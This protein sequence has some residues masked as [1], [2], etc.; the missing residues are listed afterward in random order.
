M[1]IKLLL[2]FAC[3]ILFLST[4][5][6]QPLMWSGEIVVANGSTYGKMRPRVAVASGNIP[7]VMWGG[8][9]SGEPLYAARWNGSGFDTPVM[10][11]PVNVDPF[12]DVW[13]GAEI[14]ANGNDVFVVYK[15]EPHMTNN[16]YVVKS[17]DGGIT[18][19]LPVQADPGSGPLTDLPS[20]AVTG[21]GNPSVLF[22]TFDSVMANP[23]YAIS[24][25][26]DGGLTYPVAT[27]I[28]DSASN[29]VCDCCPAYLAIKG[30]YFVP[31]WRRNN[32]NMRDMWIAVSNDG[33][34]TF[35]DAIDID[36]TDW[37]LTSCPSSGPSPFLTS[38]SVVTAFMSGASGRNRIYISTASYTT[39]QTGFTQF[40]DSSVTLNA[41][42]NYP[43]LAG[44]GDTLALVYQE[45]VSGNTDAIYAYSYTGAAGLIENTYVLNNS[46]AGNQ[47]NPHVAYASNT[48]HFVWVDYVTGNVMYKTGTPTGIFENENST[49][50]PVYPNPSNEATRIEPGLAN[51]E[52]ALLEV[53]D[54]NGRCVHAADVT[55][56]KSYL[57]EKQV[58]GVYIVKVSGDKKLPQITK[59]IFY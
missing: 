22:M 33:G 15:A 50:L 48:F 28:S 34:M 10:I 46:L 18:W 54:V 55:G 5:L 43:F 12:I 4:L 2:S 14:A 16:I 57:L 8:G 45:A 9:P 23:A 58:P 41:I 52:K 32:S 6:S 40:A 30:N 17:S 31:A 35:P 36:P 21:A 11:T 20:I 38:D 53:F 37:M 51:G 29:E 25:S 56:M 13:A 7:V 47:K 19:G 42:Q 27:T 59:I 39:L 1:K 49:P 3:C 44:S 24:T 26:T